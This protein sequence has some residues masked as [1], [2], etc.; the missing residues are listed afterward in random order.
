MAR[1]VIRGSASEEELAEMEAFEDTGLVDPTGWS[2]YRLPD[3]K[4]PV[5][6]Q[7]V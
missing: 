5:G 1:Y 7:W 3:R 2:I 6:F 4:A